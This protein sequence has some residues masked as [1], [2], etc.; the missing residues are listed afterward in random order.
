MVLPCLSS[1]RAWLWPY[2]WSTL[3]FLDWLTENKLCRIMLS[4]IASG[5]FIFSLNRAYLSAASL[6]KLWLAILGRLCS[7][8]ALWCLTSGN[9]WAFFYC[10]DG[11]STIVFSFAFGDFWWDTM[12]GA[13]LWV[14]YCLG[15]WWCSFIGAGRS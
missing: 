6:A 2:L 8:F 11:T 14:Y 4:Y 10:L 13:F 1:S 7:S 15:D 12:I 5:P 9:L 3:S